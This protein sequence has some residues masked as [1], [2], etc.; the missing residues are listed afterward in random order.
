MDNEV[1]VR[2]TV[3]DSG[4][5]AGFSDVRT[6]SDKAGERIVADA[7]KRL[8]DAKGRF[9][10]IGRELG[11]GIGKG[12]GDGVDA[13]VGKGLKGF[14][15][16]DDG[17]RK[18]EDSLKKLATSFLDAGTDAERADISKSIRKAK[19]ELTDLNK[20]KVDIK[21]L[22][23]APSSVASGF[24][25]IGISGGQAL[26]AGLAIAAPLI[27]ATISAAVI[28][29]ASA[30]G[31]LGG[32]LIAS[33]DPRVAAAGKALGETLLSDLKKDAKPFIEPVLDAIALI[34]VKFRGMNADIAAI[35]SK[36]STFLAPL[37]NGVTNA[38]SSVVHGIGALV[39][40]GEP[41]IKAFGQVFVDAGRGIDMAFEVIAGGSDDASLA[42]RDLGQ[43]IQIVIVATGYLIRWLT[44]AYGFF[45]AADDV[46]RK[47]QRGF[48]DLG[49]SVTGA[50]DS[51]AVTNQTATVTAAVQRQ[52]GSVVLSTAEAAGVA[53]LNMQTFGE[54]MT[55]AA[56]KGRG[57]F[58]SQT[59]VAE[60]IDNTTAALHKNGRTLD[61]G[62]EK[63]RANRKEL[64]NLAGQLLNNLDAQTKLGASSSEL[65]AK[66]NENRNTFIRLARQFGLSKTEAGN[67]ATE[68][69]LI[70]SKSVDFTV[71]THDS[72]GKVGAVRNALASVRSKTV[73]LRVNV[74]GDEA[75]HGH[76]A[77]GGLVGAASGGVRGSRTL[78]GEYG[79]ELVE[80]PPGTRVQSNPDTQRLM[81]GAG[82]GG[83][84]LTVRL[85]ADRSAERGFVAEVMR[86]LRAE[87]ADFYGGNVQ[88]ALGQGE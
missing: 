48:I 50:G 32:V 68:M 11:D 12:V 56:S 81:G 61:A 26:A 9:A 34:Q 47:A 30:G 23:P 71:N 22:L 82:P 55:A 17:I 27:G 60:A 35:F 16:L 24:G 25:E 58:D 5:D 65:S 85:V 31:V 8:R 46:I 87:I 21:A 83:G 28:G 59:A 63:G 7:D 13:G 14:A 18:T 67:L 54:Q 10:G 51:M 74:S 66:A 57:F 78:V 70:K 1:R 73:T 43:S 42:L 77:H 86:S 45:S 53:G 39:S 62:T 36:S 6:K 4:V 72:A 19:T 40:Q 76:N 38:V 29:G 52:V 88:L 44:E 75:L 20:Q 79:P 84:T 2:V 49:D 80:L 15:A 64:S 41:V 33:K 37:V 69:G 3:D